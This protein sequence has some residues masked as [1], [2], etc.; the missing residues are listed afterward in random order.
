MAF[1]RY[2]VWK[3]KIG[4]LPVYRAGKAP[5]PVFTENRLKRGKRKK[6]LTNEFCTFDIETSTIT[7]DLNIMFIWMLCVKG[8]Y[9]VYGRT[10]D[11]FLEYVAKIDL[12]E[13]VYLPIYVHN[14]S[15]EFQ[16]LRGLFD[17]QEDDVFVMG[18][19]RILKAKT[20]QIEFRCSY[21]LSNM[22]LKLWCEAMSVKH[23]KEDGDKFNYRKKR[24]PSTTL[25]RLEMRYA[26]MDV[27]SQ[28]EC[29]EKQL[30]F[31]NDDLYSIPQT[32]TGYV[33]RDAKKA[34]FA[35]RG[36]LRSI[37][38]EKSTMKLLREAFRGGNSHASRFYALEI[39][40]DLYSYD[41]QSSYIDNMINDKYPVS[42]FEPKEPTR[43]EFA[44]V[45][46]SGRP[47]LVKLFL[48]DIT[49]KNPFWG[50]PY[51][52]IDKCRRL[53]KNVNDNGRVL[54]AASLEI[55]LTDVDYKILE[56]EYNFVIEDI[57]ALEVSF[58]GA[59]PKP[60]RDVVL[61]Y[62]TLKTELKKV[63]GK[64]DLYT[65]SKNK[66]NATYGM[67][68]QNPVKPNIVYRDGAYV[69]DEES[70][71]DTLLEKYHKCGF[72][73]YQWGVWVTA[74]SRLRLEEGLK[75]AG[76]DAVYCDTDS[77][78][79][80]S[81]VDFSDFNAKRIECCKVS[82]GYAYDRKGNC[83]YLGVFDYEGKY[84]RFVTLGA[85]KYAYEQDGEFSI[86][87]AGVGKIKG[88]EELAARGGIAALR[89][90]FVFSAAASDEWT[91][92][93]CD[94]HEEVID[95]EM[96][97]VTPNV[98]AIPST[99]TVGLSK[100]YSDLLREV[101]QLKRFLPIRG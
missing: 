16:Y 72:L 49:L 52:P 35:M 47:F 91:Y 68:V 60:F 1:S 44:K 6:F 31:D 59:L 85:K 17:F 76:E 83:Q 82:E 99:Y 95:G 74:W 27:I 15:Y 38:P 42:K 77:V 67:T 70:D 73:P 3:Q 87:I 10:W 55:T 93:D 37:F 45:L 98:S 51:I 13:D 24:L 2:K 88:A 100:D 79:S 84:D 41:R 32:A 20:G 30:L 18:P 11:D 58:Y 19:R 12:P 29:I 56:E 92:N 40:E 61:Q 36:K 63:S 86:T 94:T 46:K 26:I 78:K 43:A 34:L 75:I 39:L 9:C 4:G 97:I 48:K 28:Y 33:R 89:E 65:K 22:S 57:L 71:F 54:E 96:V 62:Y 101:V 21:Y 7:K 81:P 14:L 25:S 90:G 5:K 80:M 50:F 66:L 64:E 23:Q 53:R 69:V 8:E